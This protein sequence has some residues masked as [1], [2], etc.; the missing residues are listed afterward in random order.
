MPDRRRG[1]DVVAGAVRPAQLPARGAEGVDLAIGRADVDAAVGDRGRRVEGSARAQP[2]LSRG[3]PEEL[4]GAR[5]E[6]VDVVVVGAEVDAAARIGHRV[7]DLAAGRERPARAP[8]RGIEGV[9]LAVP[10]A[11]IDDAVDHERRRLARPDRDLPPDLAR[12]GVERDDLAVDPGAARVARWL[13]Q[14]GHVDAV[15]VDRGRC[16]RAPACAVGPDGLHL[17]DVDREQDPICICEIE[18]PVGDR[19]RELDERAR[20]EEPQR[21][22]GRLHEHLRR[23]ALPR[24]VEAVHRPAD[25]RGRRPGDR[26][27]LGGRELLGRGATHVAALVL[28]VEADP[29]ERSHDHEQRHADADQHALH[30]LLCSTAYSREKPCRRSRRALPETGT[31]APSGK[32]KTCRPERASRL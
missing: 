2:L 5:V 29:D 8:G 31:K 12:V 24:L 21:P 27:L 3:A 6:R 20:P 22:V 9:D 15:P 18:L 23:V 19:G 32:R 7:L 26:L 14:E 13:V 1:V 10:V 17:A 4:A 11:D 16:R 25:L 28:A 30:R